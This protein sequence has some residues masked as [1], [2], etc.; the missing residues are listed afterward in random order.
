[1]ADRIDR[2]RVHIEGKEYAVV[3]GQ[4][5]AMLAVVKGLPGRR[6]VGEL[7]VWQLPGTAAELQQKVE[8]S[9]FQLEGGAPVGPADAPAPA[10]VR[11]GG[12][13]I[14]VAV[15]GQPLTVVGGEFQAMLAVVKNMPGRRFNG[16]T[17]TWDIPGEVAIIK[18]LV[19]SAGFQL[20]GAEN[21]AAAPPPAMETPNFG[22]S[23]E[24]PPYEEPDFFGD[25]DIPPYE[26]PD[27]WD[28]DNV[29]PPPSQPPGWWDEPDELA[30]PPAPHADAP[31]PFDAPP[32]VAAP[33]RPAAGRG[34]GSDQI[35][36]RIGG[37]PHLVSGG[38]FQAMLAVVKNLPGRRFDGQDKVWDIPADATIDGVKQKL[39]AAGFVLSR[40]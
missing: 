26:P 38:S 12:D 8:S 40:D 5:Q 35:R 19:E 36:I 33:S 11:P 15:N 10:A 23:I 30:P 9:G 2:I 29:P 24:P 27:W 32:P 39:E 14:R 16:E 21:I 28:D 37:I 13:R 31:P 20:E 18:Q 3:G 34:S 6:F 1:M 4:F 17:K 22:P 25:A 7:K